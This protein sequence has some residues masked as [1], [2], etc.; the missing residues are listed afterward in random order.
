MKTVLIAQTKKPASHKEA[1][2]FILG[3]SRKPLL[4]PV[5]KQLPTRIILRY[6]TGGEHASYTVPPPKMHAFHAILTLHKI[7]KYLNYMSK[8]RLSIPA[9]QT[10]D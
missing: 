8:K 1:L 5:E 7:I 2:A 9:H 3:K 6:V 10:M 4:Q